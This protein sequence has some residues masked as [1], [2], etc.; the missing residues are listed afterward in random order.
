VG[1]VL[2][3]QLEARR[4][5]AADVVEFVDGGTQGVSL[6]GHLSGRGAVLVLDAVS[7]GR[8]LPPGRV[9]VVRDPLA[10]PTAQAGGAHGANASGLLASAQLLGELPAHAVV[11]GVSPAE[12]ETGIGLSEPVRAAL[13]DALARAEAV[14][15]E[16]CESVG[17]GATPC[18]S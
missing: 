2:L 11:V 4:S 1:L 10:H 5:T 16:L 12:L 15:T 9:V 17:H 6:L 18:T 14:L 13:P 3:R 7:L 8:S